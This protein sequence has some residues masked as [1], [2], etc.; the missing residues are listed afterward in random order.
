MNYKV[1]GRNDIGDIKRCIFENRG[2][3]NI[4]EYTNL[5]D[6]I[7]IPYEKL[8]N[9]SKAVEVFTKHLEQHS[10]ISIVVDCDVD[11]QC[12]ASMIY[13]YIKSHID[14]N[15]DIEYFIHTGKQHGLSSDIIIPENTKLLIITDA[16]TNDTEQCKL[17]S[18]K[19]IDIIILDHHEKE[20]ENPYATVVNNQCSPNYTNKELCGAGIVYKFLQALDEYYWI[21]NADDYLDLVALANISDVMDLRSF[22]TKRLIDKGLSM[23][24]NKCFEEFVNSQNFLMKGKINSHTIAFYVTSLINAM[25][26]VGNS[27]EKDLLFRALIEQD[28]DFE[29]KKRGEKIPITETIYERAVRLCKNAKARQDKQVNSFLPELEE[30]YLK[31]NNAVLF[32][33]GDNIPNVFSG[34]VAMKLA[35]K[36]KKPCLVLREINPE[37]NSENIHRGSARNFDNSYVLNFK[38]FLEETNKFNW[39]QGHQGAFGVEIKNNNIK[40]VISELNSKFENTEKSLIVDF[41]IDFNDFNVGIINDITA[42]EDYYGTGIKEPLIVIKNLVLEANQGSL[43]GKDN[44]TWK[45]ITDDYAIIKFKNPAD[46]PVLN[47]LDDYKDEIKINALCQVGISEY[48]GIIT[49]Q[50]TIKEYEVIK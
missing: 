7:I 19:G 25:C 17:L 47:F 30:K 26:R 18:K 13:M 22:E 33:K 46:D 43:M 42:L 21:D 10:K 1:C 24:T 48:K 39:C 6:D 20:I 32:V 12:S 3:T 45:F 49:P 8:D 5:T 11:G 50:V 27:E 40:S 36:L 4:E 28:E 31:S 15:A 41:E 34:I 35:D 38:D 2:I 16:G 29:Y 44:D 23:I 14:K 9:I 37:D